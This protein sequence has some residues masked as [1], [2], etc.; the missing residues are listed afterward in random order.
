[1]QTAMVR[2]DDDEEKEEVKPI[3]FVRDAIPQKRFVI[4][5]EM[6]LSSETGS[7]SKRSSMS[8]SSTR[9]ST[10]GVTTS[11]ITTTTTTTTGSRSELGIGGRD[12]WK[13]PKRKPTQLKVIDREKWSIPRNAD[14]VSSASKRSASTSQSEISA[15]SMRVFPEDSGFITFGEP[16]S[17]SAGGKRRQTKRVKKRAYGSGSSSDEEEEMGMP[18]RAGRRS[19]MARTEQRGKKKRSHDQWASIAADFPGGLKDAGSGSPGFSGSP[20]VKRSDS[21]S[22]SGLDWRGDNEKTSSELLAAAMRKGGDGD[23]EWEERPKGRG[24]RK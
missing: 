3:P 15:S 11:T 22:S 20:A 19:H 17:P 7:S 16:R 10:R 9:S 14:F 8:K 23:L 18:L 6:M 5:P 4:G 21:A 13:G 2:Y 24:K 1:M 12:G